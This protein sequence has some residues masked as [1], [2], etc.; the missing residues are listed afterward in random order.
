MSNF[1]GV[2]ECVSSMSQNVLLRH[3]VS[4]SKDLKQLQREVSRETVSPF[5]RTKIG[6]LN[7]IFV[8]HSSAFQSSRQKVGSIGS[9]E[10]INHKRRH[11]I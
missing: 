4:S 8:K 1:E 9:M 6:I 11:R 10:E 5:S 3:H 2:I 7:K